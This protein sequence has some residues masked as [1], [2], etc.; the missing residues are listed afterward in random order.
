LNFTV[1]AAAPADAFIH[2]Q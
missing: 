1:K 2:Y